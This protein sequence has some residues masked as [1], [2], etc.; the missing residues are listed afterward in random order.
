[1][2]ES[3]SGDHEDPPTLGTERGG[4]HMQN[5][6]GGEVI[7][8]ATG[9]SRGCLRS[10]QTLLTR[11]REAKKTCTTCR[12]RPQKFGDDFVV[13]LG[14]R[15]EETREASSIYSLGVYYFPADQSDL[16]AVYHCLFNRK[17]RS[18]KTIILCARNSVLT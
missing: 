16:N 4:Q 17:C 9:K 14:Y 2:S 12:T 13:P 18:G 7:E 10:R 3:N 8:V 1:M 6:S 5:T 15:R 11:S